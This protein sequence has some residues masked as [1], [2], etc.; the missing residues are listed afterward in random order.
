MRVSHFGKDLVDLIG[1]RLHELCLQKIDFIYLNLS[2]THP[3]TQQICAPLEMKGFF[4]AGIIPE[5]FD[6]DVLR[7]QFLNNVDIDFE[8]VTVVSDFGKE[9]FDYV[10]KAYECELLI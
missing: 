7:L 2:L 8:K 3:M 9:I 4:F 1:F 5:M 6:G 10:V